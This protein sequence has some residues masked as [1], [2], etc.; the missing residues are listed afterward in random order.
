M[1]GIFKK[2]Q[3]T[4]M[5]GVIRAI[6]GD[7]PPAKSADLERAITIAHEDLLAEQVPI[8]EVQRIASGLF[9]GPM[10]YSTYDLAIASSLSFFKNPELFE[11]LAEIQVPARLRVLNWMKGGKVAPGVL[12]IFEDTLYR[13]YKP[14][15][16]AADEQDEQEEP[17]EQALEYTGGLADAV[18]FTEAALQWSKTWGVIGDVK[19]ACKAA[20]IEAEHTRAVNAVFE[21]N[22]CIM[23]LMQVR[24]YSAMLE[25]EDKL[26]AAT[27]HVV[28]AIRQLSEAAHA[29]RVD[30][31]G[32]AVIVKS[33]AAVLETR[34]MLKQ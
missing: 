28:K 5:D 27:E 22:D 25:Q 29:R 33:L 23:E 2:K 14:G 3:P 15:A 21:A 24:D 26:M 4:V 34:G 11:A 20:G 32:T 17:D 1:F 10:P 6:Y 30:V 7:N 18:R 9:A 16:E 12:K 13:L 8:S 19:A 31:S